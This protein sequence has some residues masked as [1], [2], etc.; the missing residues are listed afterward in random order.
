MGGTLQAQG[1]PEDGLQYLFGQLH[2]PLQLLAL[3]PTTGLHLREQ[4]LQLHQLLQVQVHLQPQHTGPSAS[5]H[6]THGGKIRLG[7]RSTARPE[8]GEQSKGSFSDGA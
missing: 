7:T 4:Q 2:P 3:G 5:R 6:R 8:D 1:F